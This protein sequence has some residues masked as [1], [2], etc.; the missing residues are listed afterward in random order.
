MKKLKKQKSMEVET[1]LMFGGV[2]SSF[3]HHV[4]LKRFINLKEKV[5]IEVIG[6]NHEESET[7]NVV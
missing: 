5:V 2:V 3:V 6:G 1:N 7:E 4:S